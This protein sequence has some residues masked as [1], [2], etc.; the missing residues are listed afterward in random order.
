MK[1]LV[2]VIFFLVFFSGCA[3]ITST[4]APANPNPKE[5]VWKYQDGLEAVQGG[6]VIGS[7]PEFGALSSIVAC[8]P[9][10]AGSASSAKAAYYAGH[11]FLWTGVA[12]M[13]AGTGV[14]VAEVLEQDDSYDK[15]FVGLGAIGG[16]IVFSIIGA[17]IMGTVFPNA[18]DAVNMYNDEYATRP[19]CVSAP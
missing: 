5:I 10:A 18:V 11:T 7:A 3:T 15:A 4:Y 14:A 13:L 6:Q 2:S 9:E 8:V 12:G 16:G 17:G 19:E 1:Y